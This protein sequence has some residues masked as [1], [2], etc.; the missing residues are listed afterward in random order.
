MPAGDQLMACAHCEDLAERI[1]WL[2]SELGI[3]RDATL[4][5]KLIEA[6]PECSGGRLQPAMTIAALFA[7]K[8]RLMSRLQIMEAVPPRENEDNREVHIVS[9]WVSR[10]RDMIGFDSIANTWGQGYRLT[11]VGMATVSGLIAP[12]TAKAA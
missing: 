2:E 5:A 12:A 9:V 6:L 8:G 7:A 1:A 11:P 3:Q 4:L 10:A